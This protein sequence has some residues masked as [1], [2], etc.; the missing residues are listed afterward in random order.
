MGRERE[1]IRKGNGACGA[2]QQ[3]VAADHRHSFKDSK[4]IGIDRNRLPGVGNVSSR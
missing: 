1:L 2:Y 3:A 4:V